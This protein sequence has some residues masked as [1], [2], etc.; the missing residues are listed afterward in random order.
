MTKRVL[1]MSY[2]DNIEK[3]DHVDTKYTKEMDK[4]TRKMNKPKTTGGGWFNMEQKP[5]N[6]SD[7]AVYKV[8]Q[9]LKLKKTTDDKGEQ[10]FMQVR[11]FLSS[12]LEPSRFSRWWNMLFYSDHLFDKLDDFSGK[13]SE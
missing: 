10:K 8:R 4:K 13:C 7:L 3:G 9:E 2:L 11:L 5:I 12:D 6:E 1:D